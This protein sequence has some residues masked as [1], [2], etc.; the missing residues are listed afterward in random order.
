MTRP[1]SVFNSV[2]WLN[3]VPLMDSTS[4]PA[5][6]TKLRLKMPARVM[7]DVGRVGQHG[8][9]LAERQGVLRS[10]RAHRVPPP[11][12]SRTA[13]GL[14]CPHS[15]TRGAA[16]SPGIALRA[17]FAT[18]AGKSSRLMGEKR[19]R[20]S[21]CPVALRSPVA[22]PSRPI[23][24]AALPRN[25]PT[26]C[27]KGSGPVATCERTTSVNGRDC[28]GF[29]RDAQLAR[30][31]IEP[32]ER[33]GG[34]DAAWLPGSSHIGDGRAGRHV[35]ES[36]RPS[37]P[38]RAGWKRDARLRPP[39]RRGHR[40][41]TV[42]RRTRASRFSHRGC[43]VSSRSR[44]CCRAMSTRVATVL[45]PTVSRWMETAWGDSTSTSRL[46]ASG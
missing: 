8:A 30:V 1:A 22:T 46:P 38:G 6:R 37:R 27:S 18:L 10:P 33:S 24:P 23:C 12:P 28:G 39:R 40:A 44:R 19:C 26:D 15:G 31:R 9:V 7:S 11:T 13:R 14:R 34:A 25:Q 29:K 5:G 16:V 36:I 43:A 21:R 2:Q 3:A 4:K 41:A 17:A 42:P 45:L 32:P 20:R 35:E